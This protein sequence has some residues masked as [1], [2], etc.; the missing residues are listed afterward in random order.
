MEKDINIIVDVDPG[1]AELLIKLIE[2]L[3]SE[4]YV[5]REETKKRMT[6]LTAAAAAKKAPKSAP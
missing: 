3:I 4:W 5:R 6:A 1:E 2:T